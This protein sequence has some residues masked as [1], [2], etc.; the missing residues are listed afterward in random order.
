[1][2]D[3]PRGAKLSGHAQAQIAALRREV[4]QDVRSG[5]DYPTLDA[6]LTDVAH[7][8]RASVDTDLAAQHAAESGKH[9]SK[10]VKQHPAA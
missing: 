5:L 10:T 2:V 7:R 1:M 4:D 8:F 6:R 9:S 3:V